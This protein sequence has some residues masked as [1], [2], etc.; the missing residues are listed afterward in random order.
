MI[1]IYMYTWLFICTYNIYIFIIY[2]NIYIYLFMFLFL[3][4]WLLWLWHQDSSSQK[5]S[6]PKVSAQ[7]MVGSRALRGSQAEEK[8][9]VLDAGRHQSGTV[10]WWWHDGYHQ[11]MPRTHWHGLFLYQVWRKSFVHFLKGSNNGIWWIPRIPLQ[12]TPRVSQF[13]AT[14]SFTIGSWGIFPT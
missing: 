8:E 11:E 13:Q 7:K 1:Y 5:M 14:I 10:A 3:R 12:S 2:T 9:T 4:L 6:C